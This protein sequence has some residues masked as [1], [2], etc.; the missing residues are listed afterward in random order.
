MVCNEP[1]RYG[2]AMALTRD[3][4]SLGVHRIGSS[5]CSCEHCSVGQP[6]LDLGSRNDNMV[7]RSDYPRLGN[8]QVGGGGGKRTFLECAWGS[9][10]EFRGDMQLGRLCGKKP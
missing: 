3:R 5:P 10:K 1:S 8:W 6:G 9:G 7:T 2:I 4:E